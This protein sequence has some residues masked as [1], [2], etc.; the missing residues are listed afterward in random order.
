MNMDAILTLSKMNPFLIKERT[1]KIL[2]SGKVNKIPKVNKVDYNAE[3]FCLNNFTERINFHILVH[4][5][6]NRRE[7]QSRWLMNGVAVGDIQRG[8]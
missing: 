2:D 8:G 1:E 5:V 4:S 3:M 7:I 6:Q